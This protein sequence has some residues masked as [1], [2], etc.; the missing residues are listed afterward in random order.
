MQTAV[1]YA[2][3]PLASALPVAQ[4]DVQEN[5]T[6][7]TTILVLCQVTVCQEEDLLCLRL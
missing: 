7:R 5:G 4:L 6:I 2:H 3:R 1:V